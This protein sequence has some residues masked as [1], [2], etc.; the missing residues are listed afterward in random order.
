MAEVCNEP[1]VAIVF[2]WPAAIASSL[3]GVVGVVSKRWLL[4]LIGLIV[5]APFLF[6]LSLTPRFGWL[7]LVVAMSYLAA[8]I[9]GWR[10]YYWRAGVLFVPMILLVSYVA[11]A[12]SSQF[13]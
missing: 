10:G 1:L 2:G 9:A 8:V 13:R 7:S 11:Y 4:M 3:L 12:V 6:Y 5:G